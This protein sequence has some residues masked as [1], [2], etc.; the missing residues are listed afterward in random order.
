MA[1]RGPEIDFSSAGRSLW[2]ALCD[3]VAASP[4]AVLTVVSDVRPDEV[5]LAEL[6]ARGERF[7]AHLSRLGIGPGDVVAV[8]LPAWSEWL[9]AASGIIRTGAVLLPVVAI[10]G[11]KE[12]AFIL[13]QS[14]AKAI[15][16]PANW[17]GTDY[18][19]VIEA[20]GGLPDLAHHIVVGDPVPGTIPFAGMIEETALPDPAPRTPDD[21]AVL[22]YTS[23]TTSAPK[24]VRHTSRTLLSELAQ[25][26]HARDALGNRVLSP[27]PPGHVAGALGMLRFM[28]N[29]ITLVLMDQWSPNEAA[30]LVEMHRISAM[31]TTPFHLAGLLDGAEA[32]GHDLSS[33]QSVMTGAAPVPS[34]LIMRCEE[35]GLHPFRCYGSSEMPTVTTGYPADPLDKR[36]TTEGRLLPG[37]QIRFVD[38]DGNDVPDGEA[39]EIALRGAELFAGYTDPALNEASF[40]E[41]GWF[42]SGDVGRL[43]AEGY[44]HI[45]DRKKDVIIRGGENISSREVEELLFDHPDIAEAAV[46]AAPDARMG[47]I[48]CAFLI[49]AP[50]RTPTLETIR[51]HFSAAG[52]AKQKTPERI[53]IVTELPRNGT[54]KVLKHE[55]RA[56]AR[57]SATGTA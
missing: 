26:A 38:D 55:L 57:E 28:T 2:Q 29:G 19:T 30:R 48:V 49:P 14:R 17:R 25:Q 50:G 18:R 52:I 45:T 35:A 22:V 3:G 42:L 36:L 56:Q 8:Q 1:Q 4:D 7:G 10:Y 46:V 13:A 15:V 21:L 40:L 41:G 11:A 23:G 9:V 16:T 53:V 24:G 12:L 27:W 43:D 37:A 31:S 39:G 5:T 47:E 54:G 33:L 51:S 44:L 32:G 6:F 20:C 34:G